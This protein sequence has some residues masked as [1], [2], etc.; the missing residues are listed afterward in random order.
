MRIRANQVQD[1][2]CSPGELK[3]QLLTTSNS[4]PGG[5]AG[6]LKKHRRLPEPAAEC[7]LACGPERP[8]F[9]NPA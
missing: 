7:T 9:G 4:R 8:L 3:A 2:I 6:H 1:G 5:G